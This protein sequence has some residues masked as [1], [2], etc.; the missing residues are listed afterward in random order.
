M[1]GQTHEP[2][3]R[4]VAWR[5]RGES[6]GRRSESACRRLQFVMKTPY[7]DKGRK[8][9]LLG[10][11]L[12]AILLTAAAGAVIWGFL[13]SREE[14]T[15]EAERERPVRAAARVAAGSGAPVI[16]V[17]R[18]AQERSGIETTRLPAAPYL[19]Q[20]RA[21]G[22]VL[23]AARLTDLSNNY[24][25]AEAQ[26][27][28]AQAKATFSKAALERAQKLYDNE[29]SVS[30]A[31]LQST[32][33]AFR[34]DEAGVGAAE[35]HVRTLA[36]TAYQEW[37]PVLGRS[38]VERS[39]AVSRLIER[40]D[41]LVQV[42][43]PPGVPVPKSVTAAAI[44]TPGKTPGDRRAA[45]TLVS[46]A[47]RTDARIQGLSFFYLVPAESGV[48]PGMNVL[49]FLS[50]GA[51]VD[52]IA[53]PAEALVWWQDRP[54][55]YRRT[56]PDTFVRTEIA[57]DQPTPAGGYIDRNL[58]RDAEIVTRGPQ[59]LLSEEFRAQIQVGDDR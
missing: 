56:E 15:R 31:L 13:E 26:L 50:S 5:E 37:G 19:D 55:V 41:F 36:A 32:E 6:A 11:T 16:R 57:T 51:S 43:L 1:E 29:R 10:G 21:Y 25:N 49:A 47:P 42:T 4:S 17:E 35:S 7:L 39:A 2:D 46:P 9:R 38:L 14:Q 3:A 34:T 54:W 18:A 22:M 12:A 8:R 23:D 24:A 52:G 58:G 45:I 40:Q 28:T 20:I 30:L 48:L 59:L 33:A 44:E 27:R 53:V